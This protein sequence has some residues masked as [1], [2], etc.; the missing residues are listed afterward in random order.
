[1]HE[2]E[3]EGLDVGLP[4]EWVYHKDSDRDEI[5]NYI[6]DGYDFI[7]QIQEEEDRDEDDITYR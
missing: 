2:I 4:N 3:E 7:R 6:K 1:M 5:L